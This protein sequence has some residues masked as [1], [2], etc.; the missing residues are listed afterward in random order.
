MQNADNHTSLTNSA[1]SGK[2]NAELTIQTASLSQQ[3]EEALKSEILAGRYKPGERIPLEEL[4]DKWGVSITPVRDAVKRLEKIG[5]VTVVPRRGVY[6][7]TVDWRTFENVFEL[8]IALECL[9][10]R[11]AS[12]LIPDDVIERVLADYEES[13]RR[14]AEGDSE[15]LVQFDHSLHDLIIQYCDNEKLIEIMRNLHD[16]N[17]LARKTLLLIRPDSY[18][19][20]LPEHLAIMRVLRAHDADAAEQAMRRH[21]TNVLERARATWK[22]Q[23]D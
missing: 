22:S 10:I 18:E 3:I 8:R 13:A 5:F 9:A 15:H 17:F 2:Q 19:Q 4:A 20:A 23:G 1:A 14:L 12:Q 6:A 7:S 11:K 21:L 16:L